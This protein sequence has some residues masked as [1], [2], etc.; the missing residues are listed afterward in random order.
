MRAHLILLIFV[1]VLMVACAPAPTPV[2]TAAPPTAAPAPVSPTRA[3]VSPT[4][5]PAPTQAVATKAP[6]VTEIKIGVLYPLTGGAAQA[7]LDAKA[8]VELAA[9]IINGKYPDV[10]LPLAKPG[11]LPGLGG[12]K[13][14][15]IFVDHQGKPEV[16][17]SEA[18]R[19]L[20]N[21]KVI[22]LYGA[23]HSSVTKTASNVAER[24]GIPFVNGESSSPDLTERGFKWFFR[25]SPHDLDFSRAM[26]DLIEALNKQKSAGIKTASIL[27][28]DTDFGTNSANAQKA[29][30]KRVGITIVSELKYKAN[31]TS[32]SAEIQKL[33]ADKADVFLPS[34]YLS[35]AILTLKTMKELDY[36]PKMIIAQNAGYV[37]STFIPTMGKDAEG[38]LSRTAF[39]IDIVDVK[40]LAKKINE[41]YKSRTNRDLTD[42]PAR[43]FT[44]FYTLVEAI[45]RAG[46]TE[47][48]AIRQAL[49]ATNLP[50]DQVIMPW[51]GV[52]FNAKGQNELGT[53]IIVQIQDGKYKTVFPFEFKVADLIYPLKPWAE[54]K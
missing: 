16:G 20:N 25:T 2:P 49:G 7:G 21:E 45:N 6:A 35:D 8:A 4:A 30:A 43:A 14:T 28:E 23:Y 17:Q 5:T 42:V 40:P 37:D 46:T 54:R 47:P 26:F 38:I 11:G 53:A 48:D 44:G 3:P 9:D 41:L 27:A 39:A 24:A 13:V 34:S 19:L 50:A 36:T 31:T 22:A 32:L 51:K 33:K 10:A 12:A 52:K 29:E 1:L 18:E 15:P